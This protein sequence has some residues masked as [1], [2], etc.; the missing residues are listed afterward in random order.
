MY[1][2]ARE[3]FP[4]TRSITGNGVRETLEILQRELLNLQTYE[5]P[6]GTSCFDWT[7][8]PE[9]NVR[10]A[11]ITAPDGKKFAEL[12]EHNLH[13]VGYSEPVTVTL[14]LAELQS[15]LHSLPERPEA[16]PYVTSYYKR[17]WGFCLSHKEREALQPGGYE[18]F[19][20]STL[21]DKGHLTYGECFLPS[22]TGSNE[23][24]FLS[25]YV[26]HPSMANNELSGPVVATALANWL[27]DQAERRFCYRFV[28][29]PETIGA[30]VYLSRNLRHLQE[31]TV[32]GFNISCV[33]DDDTYSYLPSRPG[34]TLSDDISKHVLDNLVGE[35][36]SYTFLD[37]GSDERQYCAPGV[38]LPVASVMRSKFGAYGEYHTS[39]DNL[40]FISPT[41]LNGGFEALRHCCLSLEANKTYKA[42]VLG[43]PQLGKYG[44]YP[45]V[46]KAGDPKP[47]DMLNILA[48]SDGR[49]S[50]LDIAQ[51]INQPIWNLAEPAE[52]LRQAGLLDDVTN[53]R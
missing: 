51:Q 3:L 49:T 21:D 23:E 29:I 33:G 9:W 31:H 8:P 28:F 18:V 17:N 6:S 20:D 12:K 50:L 36:I 45:S 42:T 44:L 35:Y 39:D 13:L 4:I 15:H 14:D 46:R 40:D 37:R 32:A 24:I 30:I 1:A 53:E 27:A 41:G 7:V 25:T 5:V 10:D 11:Y 2:L 22:T 43:E 16:I 38:D 48:Y 34:D 52:R 19:I 26:C 47:K